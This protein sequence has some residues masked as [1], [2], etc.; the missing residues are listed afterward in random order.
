MTHVDDVPA[1][2]ASTEPR[3]M[4]FTRPYM[5]DASL[6]PVLLAFIGHVVILLV[7]VMLAVWRTQNLPAVG[8]L[9]IML[10]GSGMIANTERQI[11][12][13]LG[14]FSLV[15]LLTWI[16]GVALSWVCLVTNVL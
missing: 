9:I 13:R 3:W 4:R 16:A 8:T 7:P 1:P 2:E 15:L 6:R 12:G 10:V 14:A 11:R 5:E